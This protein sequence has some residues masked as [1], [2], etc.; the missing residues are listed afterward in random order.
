[1]TCLRSHRKCLDESILTLVFLTE[2]VLRIP[3]LRSY[4]RECFVNAKR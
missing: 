3:K 4:V 2:S 1:M